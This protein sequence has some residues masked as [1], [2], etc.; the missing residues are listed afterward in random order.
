MQNQKPRLAVKISHIYTTRTTAKHSNAAT[1]TAAIQTAT[2]ARGN[3]DNM[4]STTRSTTT[5]ND[6]SANIVVSPSTNINIKINSKN[7]TNKNTV[8]NQ[9]L[10]SMMNA[11]TRN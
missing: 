8:T 11:G 3:R 4:Y 7:T 6:N 5:D 9:F 10:A 1:G 2:I